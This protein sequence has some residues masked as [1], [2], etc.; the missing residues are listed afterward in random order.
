MLER[1]CDVPIDMTTMQDTRSGSLCELGFIELALRDSLTETRRASFPA[2]SAVPV[3]LGEKILHER[4]PWGTGLLLRT[5]DGMLI[6]IAWRQGSAHLAV[7]GADETLVD[8]L[9]QGLVA[10]LRDSE[11][12][13]GCVPVTFWA[14]GESP[15]SARRPRAP[16]ATRSS[17][18]RRRTSPS[19][20]S[21]PRG[22]SPR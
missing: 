16:G 14:G 20:A 6:M 18:R 3:D 5:E 2:R 17:P 7:A 12:E 15:I 10:R 9:T 19:G 11:L 21:G 22:R 13:D 1:L 8:D 4:A